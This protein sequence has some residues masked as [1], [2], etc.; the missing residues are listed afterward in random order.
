MACSTAW[1]PSTSNCWPAAPGDP[2]PFVDPEGYQAHIDEY[3]E[4]FETRLEEQR[5]AAGTTDP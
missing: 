3:E 2:N 1:T 5:N 4:I